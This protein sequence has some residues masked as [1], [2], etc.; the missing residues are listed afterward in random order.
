M[1]L[2]EV[3]L[4]LKPR[5]DTIIIAFEL[6]LLERTIVNDARELVGE[7]LRTKGSSQEVTPSRDGYSDVGRI[8][9]LFSPYQFI[10]FM[11]NP[12][13][14]TDLNHFFSIYDLI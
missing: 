6:S 13:R 5:Y 11:I 3:Q 12:P 14:Y 10:D 8:A 1:H 4:S 9:N 2:V 7:V